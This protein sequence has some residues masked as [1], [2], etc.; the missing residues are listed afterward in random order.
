MS[1]AQ[2]KVSLDNIIPLTEARDHF[3]QIV[4]EV[5]KDK[6]Y[7]LTKGGKPAVAIIDV[8]YL[9]N[10]TGGEIQKEHI[11]QEIQ[12]NPEKVGRP[13]MIEHKV[14]PPIA[15][16]EPTLKTSVPN[17]ASSL[18]DNKSNPAPAEPKP[19]PPPP[20]SPTLP[21]T[22]P[23]PPEPKP[24][25]EVKPTPPPKPVLPP[26]PPT[27]PPTSTP[28]PSPNPV[29]S[30]P[31]NPHETEVKEKPAPASAPTETIIETS[32]GNTNDSFNP[33]SGSLK[34]PPMPPSATKQPEKPKE[35]APL[36][37]T[38]AGNI[39]TDQ[40]APTMINV[41]TS[42]DETEKIEASES[43]VS[44]ED[45]AGPAQYDGGHNDKSSDPDDMMID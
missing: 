45:T 4:N 21:E 43:R 10:L 32:F 23:T 3:S 38:P 12:K 5:Q 30:S 15:P 25:P 42:D 29:S 1:F 44:P 8:K 27:P 22:K 13:K 39:Q 11:E 9:E 17:L 6:L 20:P 35:A 36:P 40:S 26:A 2:L 41:Q 33:P 7:V 31:A 24:T 19:V 14:T 34:T 37:K 18:S 28:P 16:V